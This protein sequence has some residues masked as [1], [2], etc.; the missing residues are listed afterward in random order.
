M[1]SLEINGLHYRV[2]PQGS[3]ERT[4]IA[5]LEHPRFSP[6]RYEA[7]EQM[8]HDDPSLQP[9]WAVKKNGQW[10]VLENRFPFDKS[11]TGYV[12]ETFRDFSDASLND[13][14]RT[15][16]NRANHSDVINSQGLMVLKQTFRNWADASSARIPRQELADPLLML[17]VITRTTNT[18]WLALPPSDAAGALRRLDF[19]P[20]H[21]STEWNNFNADPSNYNLKRLVGSV[22]VRN[23]YEA[24]PLTIEHRGPTLVFTR[25]NHDTVFFLKLGRVDG[26]A[27]RDITPPGNELSDPN[28]TARIGVPARTALLTAYAQNKV[29]WLLGGTQTTSSG[30][31]SVF[32][33]RE[34]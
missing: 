15:L 18:G 4:G 23:G 24:F 10:E 7:F 33:I 12:A 9:R 5:F 3:P 28:L 2:V 32:I 29:V 16:F 31:Q 6:S 19:A 25:A 21:F 13:V 34:G 20:N 14:A 27:I 8:L 1:E 22:L 11:L 26:Y 30:W 17:P